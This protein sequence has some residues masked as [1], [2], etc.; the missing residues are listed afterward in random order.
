MPPLRG[1]PEL[2]EEPTMDEFAG[3]EEDEDDIT[4]GRCNATKAAGGV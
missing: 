1:N 3:S 2:K 4:A